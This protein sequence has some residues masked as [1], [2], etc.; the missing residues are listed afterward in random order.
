MNA[1][2]KY[3]MFVLKRAWIVAII[4]V[5][6]GAALYIY[7]AR[8]PIL[9]R[10]EAKIFVGSALE[11]IDP[12]INSVTLG[13]RL[14]PT[15]AE[16]ART[17][18]IL[19]TTIANLNLN[20][21]TEDLERKIDTRIII[22][23]AILVIR[24]TDP[25]PIQAQNI[26]NEHAKNLIELSPSALTE[27][28]QRLLEIQ[29]ENINQIQD[30]LTVLETE[31]RDLS[32]QITVATQAGNPREIEIL[33]ERYSRVLDRIG[34]LRATQAQFS[35][36]FSRYANRVN[37]LDFFENARAELDQS[38]LNPVI[39]A[40]IGFLGGA[41]LA[42]GGLLFFVEYVDDRLRTEYETAR[43]LDLPVMGAIP[44][45]QRVSKSHV[46]LLTGGT[47]THDPIA[48]QYRILQTNLMLA[49]DAKQP[50]LTYV[51]ASANAVDG[52]SFTAAN[53]AVI[54]AEYGQQVLLIDADLRHPT[55]HTLFNLRNDVGLA[56]LLNA[57]A[58]ERDQLYKLF[59][60]A[61]Q[62]TNVNR[63]HV[64]TSGL[65]EVEMNA[66]LFGFDLL[67]EYMAVIRDADEYDVILFDT[68]P[69]LVLADSVVVAK[70]AHANIILVVEYARTSRADAQKIKER[71]LH[72]KSVISG[73]ILNKA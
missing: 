9:Y 21:D 35:E 55:M 2:R 47:L 28:E 66:K 70:A 54:M 62:E 41:G 16:L 8:Q 19:E 18:D 48:E 61:V 30:A 57:D 51:I 49:D 39:A 45:S 44:R 32:A 25:D 42:I 63:L 59:R 14:A 22:D 23:T 26:A 24:V 38:R 50:G 5:L 11:D 31:A 67:R 40:V 36:T 53:L 68:P 10:A 15:F 27:Q 72:A 17:T 43:A 46:E 56:T 13:M 64:L 73:V 69:S 34:Q 12:D 52:R 71:F 33:D 4:A 29:T 65:D 6:G 20:M 3:L 58:G 7:F 37:R 1:I 60:N